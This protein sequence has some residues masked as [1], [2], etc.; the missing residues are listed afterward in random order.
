MP[1]SDTIPL[2]EAVPTLVQLAADAEARRPM[3]VNILG[4]D[5]RARVARF[6]TINAYVADYGGPEGQ[7]EIDYPAL[8]AIG[9]GWDWF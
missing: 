8:Q 9:V 3:G 7:V 1:T 5:D 4:D 2:L 6:A